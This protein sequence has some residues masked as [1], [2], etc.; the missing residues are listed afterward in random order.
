MSREWLVAVALAVGS[1]LVVPSGCLELREQ[2][3]QRHADECTTCHG[4]PVRPG[5]AL[6]R[7]A[8]PFDL[9]GETATSRRGVGA[10]LI[11]LRE[12]DLTAPIAC[13]ECHRVPEATDT[14]GHADDALPAEVTFGPRSQLADHAPR[15][16]PSAVSCAD[17][18][19]HGG[20]TIAWSPSGEGEPR[21]ARCHG[22]PPAAPHPDEARC[23]LCHGEVVDEQRRIVARD[24]H[25]DGVVQV[26]ARCDACHG[27]PEDGAPP[28]DLSGNTS[29]S[30]VG[31]GAH[32]VHLDGGSM[33]RP[34]A[35][36]ECHLVPETVGDAG[37][38]DSGAAEVLLTGVAGAQDRAPLYDPNQRRC[39]D[40]WC[41]GPSDAN[42][43]SPRWT[44]ATSLTCSGCHG[45]PPAA[46]HP[47]IADCAL[48]HAPVAGASG[49]IAS[50]ELHVDGVVQVLVPTACNACH[51]SATSDAPSTGAHAIHLAPEGPFRAVDC[52]DCHRVP[53]QVLAAGHI[54]SEPPAEVDFGGVAEAFSASPAFDGVSC[55]GTWCHGG[56]TAFGFPSGGSDTAPSWNLP[57]QGSGC[58]TC[59]A[60]P[61][62]TPVHPPGPIFCSPCHSNVIGLGDFIDP[63]RHVDGF[64]DL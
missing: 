43:A 3:Q 27:R 26:Q 44:D 59:H 36:G 10:H 18:H 54:D 1:A 6:T 19:C 23:H 21:C 63:S 38:I 40:S 30:A 42:L 2:P 52:S 15:Y 14:P 39:V 56:K 45:D 51:G 13:Q 57:L 25:I 31:V 32:L 33:S 47:Q 5:D 4:S 55:G 11:H 49:E 46:P 35:C 9:A 29:R 37:H 50:P 60:M 62:P 16:N 8:P 64:I 17:T 7:S 20:R 28:P 48:C 22:D 24:L 34:L 53:T 58:T 12:G 61:P 41:H